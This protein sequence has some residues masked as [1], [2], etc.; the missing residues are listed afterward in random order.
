MRKGQKLGR[1]FNISDRSCKKCGKTYSPRAS[2]QLYCF[3]CIK[4][5]IHEYGKK[6]R[7]SHKRYLSDQK[8]QHYLN[9]KEAYRKRTNAW[10]KNNKSKVRR[11]WIAYKTKTRN[12]AYEILAKDNVI[13]C[14]FFKK[15]KCC[16]GQNDWRILQIDHINGQGEKHR[17]SLGSDLHKW[18]RDN[19]HEAREILQIA[20]ANAQW[21]KRY[22][23]HEVP[24]KKQLL[25]TINK[26]YISK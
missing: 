10:K 19:P 9:H 4:L 21:I 12:K 20:C 5:R 11:S 23:E 17:R 14:V 26:K 6:Y 15:Y 2:N 8:R 25:T 3:P 7:G 1:P 13:R 24:P 18:I 16:E 22:E